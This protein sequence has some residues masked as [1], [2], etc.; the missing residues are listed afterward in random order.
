LTLVPYTPLRLFLA[1]GGTGLSLTFL[2]RNLYPVL[3]T[4]TKSSAKLL[5]VVVTGLHLVLGMVMW[6]AFMADGTGAL[7]NLPE[8]VIPPIVPDV[9]ETVGDVMRMRW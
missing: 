8:V 3:A 1:L 9:P 4:S 2:L 5:I 7:S 6:F